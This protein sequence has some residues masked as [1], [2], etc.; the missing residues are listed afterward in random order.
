MR[1]RLNGED[2]D[3]ADGTTLAQLVDE[4]T[5]DRSRVAVERN[6]EIAPRA[7]WN[8][9]VVAEGDEVEVVTLVGGG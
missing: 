2:R 1:V 9:V 8:E 4:I 3:F 7:T 6:R 5:K